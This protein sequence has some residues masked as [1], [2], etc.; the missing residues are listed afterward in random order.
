[1]CI[2]CTKMNIMVYLAKTSKK[3]LQ[4]IFGAIFSALCHQFRLFNLGGPILLGNMPYLDSVAPDQ[5][6]RSHSMI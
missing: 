5:S 6:S 3:D 4:A 1:M 2:C